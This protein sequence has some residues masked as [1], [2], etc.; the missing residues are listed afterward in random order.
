MDVQVAERN[1]LVPGTPELRSVGPLTFGSDGVLFVADNVSA[2]IYA[3]AVDD[4][5]DGGGPIEVDQLDTRL[6]ALL[7][8]AKDDVVIR[9]LA[10]HP[11]SGAAYLS[12]MR[13]HGADAI[14]VLVRAGADGSLAEV[15]L[16]GVP[17]GRTSIEDAPAED[18]TRVVHRLAEGAEPAEELEVRG[19]TLRIVRD[20]MRAVTVTDL[21]FADGTLLVAG[22]SNEEFTS[23]LRRIP[24]PFGEGTRSNSLE[25]FHVSH[26]RFE[27]EAPV[28]NLVPYG[29]SGDI[30]ASYTCTPVVHFSLAEAEP[31]AHVKGRTVAELGAMNTPLDMVSFR[32]DGQEYL[33]VANN[34][35]PMFKLACA[36]IDG[37]AGLTDQASGVGV[38]RQAVPLDGVLR[39]AVRGREEVVML[40]RD[41]DGGR[42][43]RTH[44]T[45]GL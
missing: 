3:I 24:F 42:N 30:L 43:L 26:G 37:Q 27:T 1:G 20:P 21:A 25:I 8:C 34:R 33:L 12:V 5:G 18:D 15:P 44:A 7:G 23:C 45:H 36:D 6:A 41:E 28:R 35:H 31:G 32:R 29:A 13:G 14:P 16:T 19:L 38:P 22:A 17:F 10:V 40:Q 4:P 9:D 2:S 39:M 11:D